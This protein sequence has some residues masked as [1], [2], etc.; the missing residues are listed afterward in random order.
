M[1]LVVLFAFGVLMCRIRVSTESIWFASGTHA[2]WNFVTFG[3]AGA[4]TIDE[5]PAAFVLLKIASIVFGLVLAVRVARTSKAPVTAVPAPP[6]ELHLAAP[7]G[8]SAAV[9][10]RMPLPP[11]PPPPFHR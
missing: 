5:F 6:V 1:Q 3:I 2:L 8:A 9:V 10:S 11:P 7:T 4:Y